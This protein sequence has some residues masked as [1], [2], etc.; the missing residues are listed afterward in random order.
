MN[1][2][3]KFIAA[4]LGALLCGVFAVC[5][6]ASASPYVH[7]A[8]C[9][10]SDGTPPVGGTE[11][12]TCQDFGANDTVSITLHTVVV[13]LGTAPTDASGNVNT[14]VTLPAEVAGQHTI[15]VTDPTTD[16]TASV[17]ITIGGS[18]TGGES[19][20]SGSG[21]TSATG[22]AVMTLLGVAVVFLVGGGVLLYSG[23]RRKARV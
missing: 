1:A 12:L 9:A 14:T 7:A 15:E 17:S 8:S 5:A 3:T 4:M 10:V 22:V 18:G 16:Q 6:S 20:G 13:N 11:N 23:R 21:T 19:A 2:A